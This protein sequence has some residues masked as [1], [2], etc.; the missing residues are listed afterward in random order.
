M[1]ISFSGAAAVSG[2]AGDATAG[3]F[4]SEEEAGAASSREGA[5]VMTI[6]AAG[7]GVDSAAGGTE[8]VGVRG[9]STGGGSLRSGGGALGAGVAF[10]GADSAGAFAGDIAGSVSSA[11]RMTAGCGLAAA[12][13]VKGI[14]AAGVGGGEELTTAAEAGCGTA[15]ASAILLAFALAVS[16]TLIV[17]PPGSLASG[18][19]AGFRVCSV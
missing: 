12:S 2:L 3:S 14:F 10:T 7:A 9:T 18:A 15:S 6:S 16:A 5:E 8:P 11:L 19:R 13:A 1:G 17:S 4:P